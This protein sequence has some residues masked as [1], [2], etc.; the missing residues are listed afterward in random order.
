MMEQRAMQSLLTPVIDTHFSQYRLP[1]MSTILQ[2]LGEGH[3]RNPGINGTGP[4]MQLALSDGENFFNLFVARGSLPGKNSLIRISPSDQNAV[5]NVWANL[6]K[7]FQDVIY[8][9]D[10]IK[11]LD[12]DQTRGKIGNPAE[13][14]NICV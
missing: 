3:I 9:H 5:V 2:V 4:F 13:I 11:I 14:I 10:F 1:E 12:G 6:K 7:T 8:I